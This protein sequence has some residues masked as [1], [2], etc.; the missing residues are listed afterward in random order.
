[1]MVDR[2][3]STILR[4]YRRRRS[5]LIATTTF[6]VFIVGG[7]VLGLALGLWVIQFVDPNNS[8]LLFFK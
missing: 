4:N 3:R 5:S 7:A 1:M 2:Y 8:V 6:L